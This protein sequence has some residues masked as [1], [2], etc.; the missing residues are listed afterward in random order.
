MIDQTIN[1]RI[2]LAKLFAELGYKVGAEIGV[3]KGEY[4]EIL[5]SYNPD[6]HLYC[7]DA[8]VPYSY[9]Q[10]SNTIESCYQKTVRR[11]SKYNATIIRK[12]SMEALNDISDDSL[13]FVYID[14]GHD[15][16]NVMMDIICWSRKVRQGG[17]VSG[18][19]YVSHVGVVDAVNVYAK[20]HQLDFFVTTKDWPSFF[21]IKL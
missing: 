7:V 20:Q 5:L 16:D 15:F 4:S 9:V 12:S 11:L 18:H 6:L 10:D 17:I 13:D 1:T 21:W 2:D 8:W 3:Y 19:D 14:A